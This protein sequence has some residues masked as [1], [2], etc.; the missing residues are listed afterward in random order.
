[1]RKRNL[2]LFGSIVVV[3]AIWG[4]LYWYFVMPFIDPR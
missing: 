3:A 2:I 4:A 1:M